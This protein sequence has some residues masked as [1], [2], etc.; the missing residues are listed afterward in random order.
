MDKRKINLLLAAILESIAE[1]DE[2]ADGW[3]YAALMTQ[4]ITLDQFNFL[5]ELLLRAELVEVPCEHVLRITDKG[6]KLVAKI[7]TTINPVGAV[8]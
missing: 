2:A 8:V 4:N 6:R 5:R 7:Q 3:I 1:V